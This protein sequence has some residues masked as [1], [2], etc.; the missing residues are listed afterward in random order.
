MY[1]TGALV[2]ATEKQWCKTNIFL[3]EL[4][5][6]REW[7]CEG[8]RDHS[9]LCP[10]CSP[11]LILKNISPQKTRT[12]PLPQPLLPKCSKCRQEQQHWRTHLR[13]CIWN[14]ECRALCQTY[15][16]ECCW[17]TTTYTQFCQAVTPGTGRAGISLDDILLCRSY[18]YS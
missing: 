1:S 11:Q 5:L 15:G 18:I 16:M 9:Q 12:P 10:S 14:W 7:W 17:L 13:E 4:I 8:P 6:A 3:R 2:G